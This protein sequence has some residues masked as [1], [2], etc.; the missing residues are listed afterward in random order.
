MESFEDVFSHGSVLLYGHKEEDLYEAVY[1]TF[2]NAAIEG[3]I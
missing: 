3:M 2:L 1:Q